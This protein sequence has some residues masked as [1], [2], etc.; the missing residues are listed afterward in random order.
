MNDK[1]PNEE[2]PTPTTEVD[3]DGFQ[4]EKSGDNPIEI[5]PTLRNPVNN[6]KP[7]KTEE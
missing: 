6:E 5:V 7:P 2:T 1:K 4:N 3:G